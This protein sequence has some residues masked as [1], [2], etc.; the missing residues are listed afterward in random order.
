MK[1]L[2]RPAIVAVSVVLAWVPGLLATPAQ[3]L[4]PQQI[5]A[6]IAW[7]RTTRPEP[8]DLRSAFTRTKTPA[9]HVYTPYLRV[10]L[11]ARFAAE[12]GLDFTVHDVT[13]EMKEPLVYFAVRDEGAPALMAP[14]IAPSMRLVIPRAEPPAGERVHVS[15]TWMATT[16]PEYLHSREAGQHARYVVAAFPI[17]LLRA[18]TRVEVRRV[19]AKPNGGALIHTIPGSITARDLADWK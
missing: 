14:D 9:G 10:A 5:S 18:G 15:P 13:S 12:R 19:M 4:N 11:A 6:A 7:G 1:V 2:R 8:Y 16:L 17:G 3:S